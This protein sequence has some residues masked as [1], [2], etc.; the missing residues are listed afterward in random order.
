MIVKVLP[1]IAEENLACICLGC[2][3][4]EEMYYSVRE[5]ERKDRVLYVWGLI[6][7]RGNIL[8]VLESKTATRFN[9]VVHTFS[10]HVQWSCHLFHVNQYYVKGRG[11]LYVE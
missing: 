11:N 10:R 5:K 7:Y 8:S 3:P 4:S 9:P 2:S 6:W 1:G